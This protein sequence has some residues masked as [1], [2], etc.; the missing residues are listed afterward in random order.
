MSE[1]KTKLVAS[2]NQN[3]ELLPACVFEIEVSQPLPVLSAFDART[4]TTYR[5]A[6]CMI[7]VHSQPLGLIELPFSAGQALPQDY[8]ALIWKSYGERIGEHLQNDGLEV[9]TQLGVAGLPTL[10]LPPCLKARES[11]LL[12]APF[13]SIIVPTRD[14]PECVEACLDALLK[15]EYPAYEILLVDSAPTSPAT[16]ELVARVYAGEERVRYLKCERPGASRARN[17][18]MQEAKGEIL[19]FTDDDAVADEHWL[20]ELVRAFSSAE[21]VV[22]VTGSVCAMRFETL[23]QLWFVTYFR[24]LGDSEKMKRIFSPQIVESR[25]YYKHLMGNLGGSVNMATTA[26]FLRH[27]GGFD[28]ALGP[29]TP[30]HAAED[31][32]VFI[33]ANMHGGTYVYEPRALVYHVD[34]PDFPGLEKQIHGYGTSVPVVLLKCMVQYP[35]IA[36]NFT[37]RVTSKI[38]S[39]VRSRGAEK[40]PVVEA[41]TPEQEG[42]WGELI[43]WEGEK[44]VTRR[45]M[46]QLLKGM[47][48]GPFALI[49][50]V[51]FQRNHRD[52]RSNRP[53]VTPLWLTDLDR[54]ASPT[55]AI[56]APEQSQPLE[57]HV[58][59]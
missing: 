53:S 8:A 5:R 16:A 32:E 57:I 2:Q 29:G 39:F 4:K 28:P 26:A 9:P 15:L 54:L 6:F 46:M 58:Y 34:R 50:S 14:H 19:A 3:A 13:V 27:I 51:I 23:A 10:E 37:R 25:M 38:F 21:K 20:S 33:Q 42:K 22:C 18:G 35:S 1:T 55:G 24:G 59:S 45:V 11:F 44:E 43:G 56:H 47:A 40:A 31:V 17:L 49:K 12:S 52:V 36:R 41:Q 48:T 30:V 7:R